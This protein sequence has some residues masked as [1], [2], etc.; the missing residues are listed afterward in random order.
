MNQTDWLNNDTFCFISACVMYSHL[1]RMTS[2]E[3]LCQKITVQ[4]EV[5]DIAVHFLGLGLLVTEPKSL[6]LW[7][8][9]VVFFH[10]TF[11]LC[12]NSISKLSLSPLYLSLP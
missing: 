9:V 1:L 2:K 4:R 7:F 6:F 5:N 8:K 3:Y 10:K 12:V 11:D